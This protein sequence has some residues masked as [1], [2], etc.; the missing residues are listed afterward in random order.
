MFWPSFNSA[1][2]EGASQHRTQINTV[3]AISGSVMGT[4]C[5][6][7]YFYGKLEMELILNATL[8]GGVAIGSAS[9]L[10]TVPWAAILVGYFGGVLSSFGFH[11][12][13]PYLKSS[14]GLEDTC[15]VHSLH[16][17][18]GVM[19]AIVSAIT[20]AAAGTESY[21]DG[22]FANHSTANQQAKAQIWALLTTLAISIF[23]GALCGYIA[24]WEIWR[25]AKNLFKDDDHILDVDKKYPS[26]FRNLDN[27]S[28]GSAVDFTQAL[29]FMRS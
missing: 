7:R 28:Y 17:M 13:G 21:T 14:Y 9:D 18:P 8:A 4:V 2:A 25:P 16:G 6:S 1:L 10:V 27:H 3:L 20:V 22:Y 24:S 15:G 19:G 12:I 29:K 11:K 5:V 23:S 26:D